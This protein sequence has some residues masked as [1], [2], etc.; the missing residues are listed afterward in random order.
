MRS[1]DERAFTLI[2]LMVVVAIVGVL[3]MLATYGVRQYMLSAKGAE[4]RNVVGQLAKDAKTAYERESMQTS[5]LA[6]GSS[7]PV[8]NNL[9]LDAASPVPDNISK[10]SGRKYQSSTTD[11]STGN[12]ATTGFICLRFSLTD[13]QYFQYDYKGTIGAS[14]TFSAIGHGDLDGNGVASTISLSGGVNQGV[15]YVAPSFSEISP[16]E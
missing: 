5:L 2:E 14:G 13:P 12:S 8:T 4:V 10:V 7:T 11:W 1:P 3:A 6:V 16:E 9:C 15:V